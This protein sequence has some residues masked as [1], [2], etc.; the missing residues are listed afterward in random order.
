MSKGVPTMKGIKKGSISVALKLNSKYTDNLSLAVVESR[1]N[2]VFCYKYIDNIILIFEDSIHEY[3]KDALDFFIIRAAVNTDKPV[4]CIYNKPNSNDLMHLHCKTH[5]NSCEMIVDKEILNQ[6]LS[7]EIVKPLSEY[8]L[9]TRANDTELSGLLSIDTRVYIDYT[10]R[11]ANFTSIYDVFNDKLDNLS[12]VIREV[13]FDKNAELP[14]YTNW[15]VNIC[16]D[17]DET[18]T[19]DELY[20]DLE[21]KTEF[22]K[23]LR[24]AGF[25]YDIVLSLESKMDAR[26]ED[27]YMSLASFWSAENIVYYNKPAR[28]ISLDNII[29]LNDYY[30]AYIT[31][32]EPETLPFVYEQKALCVEHSRNGIML[33]RTEVDFRNRPI[34]SVGVGRK[35]ASVCINSSVKPS[36]FDAA[37]EDLNKITDVIAVDD[38]LTVNCFE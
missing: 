35:T 8:D 23:Q 6:L 32:F 3:S 34:L 33:A 20:K 22:L 37:I 27:D 24:K 28:L 29:Y 31:D 21:D 5:S 4:Y 16:Y 2:S 15:L 7:L 19:E 1:L 18:F 13:H 14:K 26:L 25:E 10:G 11:C 9:A 30:R 38:N 17:E 36:N 12:S